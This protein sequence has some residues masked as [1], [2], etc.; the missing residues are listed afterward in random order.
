MITTPEH[1][2]PIT[3]II[4]GGVAVWVWSIY[5]VPVG[6]CRDILRNFGFAFI[7]SYWVLTP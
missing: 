6:Q 2:V 5:A 4:L 1:Y 7:I 3:L